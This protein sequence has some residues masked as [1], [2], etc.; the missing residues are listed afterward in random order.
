MR[1]KEI[2]WVSQNFSITVGSGYDE[3]VSW[4]PAQAGIQ[5]LILTF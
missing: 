3:K 1:F 4:I 5:T 2:A